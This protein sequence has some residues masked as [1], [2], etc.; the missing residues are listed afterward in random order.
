MSARDVAHAKATHTEP[1]TR[2][3]RMPQRIILRCSGN[4]GLSAFAG[5]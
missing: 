2:P 4:G 5:V 3:Q 1:Q